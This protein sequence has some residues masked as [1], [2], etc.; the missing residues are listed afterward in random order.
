MTDLGVQ[1][2]RKLFWIAALI[3]A[4]LSFTGWSMYVDKLQVTFLHEASHGMAA[5]LTGGRVLSI[6]LQPDT[7]GVCMS[8]GGFRPLISMAGYMGSCLFGGAML[9]AARKRGWAR[10]TLLGLGVFMVGFTVLFGG[11]MVA[12][13]VGLGW[14]AF[15]IWAGLKGRG[16]QL[17][18]LL[19]FMAIRNSLNAVTDLRVLL[20]IS[21]YGGALTD[22]QIMSNTFTG[23]L[24][25]AMVFAV[26]IS[27]ASLAILGG[28]IYLAFKPD[29]RPPL[30]PARRA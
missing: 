22:A 10:W 29:G 13:L 17:A 27:L 26:I 11:N 21:G 12:W 19:S 6:T 8:A 20:H 5:L 9:V 2:E 1:P 16:W 4:V 25:P 30:E 23:G 14:G 28:F 3:A 18:L 24:V 15:F 7:S